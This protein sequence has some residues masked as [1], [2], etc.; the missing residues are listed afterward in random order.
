[1][2]C[3]VACLYLYLLVAPAA[4]HHLYLLRLQDWLTRL[5]GEGRLLTRRGTRL[6]L[7]EVCLGLLLS[8]LD[9]LF[10]PLLLGLDLL[11][12]LL[13]LLVPSLAFGPLED[14]HLLQVS[15]V[16]QFVQQDVR[17]VSHLRVSN[18][19]QQVVDLLRGVEGYYM[20]MEVF[21]D[22]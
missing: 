7:L 16:L 21:D 2:G 1:M 9:W 18:Q 12:Q 15:S 8:E 22:L 19:G 14:L 17:I 5:L 6:A 10:G 3:I 13:L 20:R 4:A 11:L